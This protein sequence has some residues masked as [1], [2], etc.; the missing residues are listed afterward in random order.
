MVTTK[1]F[2]EL[3][4]NRLKM[5]AG[6]LHHMYKPPISR[7]TYTWISFFYA[8]IFPVKR[9]TNSQAW[10]IWGHIGG[11][12]RRVWQQIRNK[13]VEGRKLPGKKNSIDIPDLLRGRHFEMMVYELSQWALMA[14]LWDWFS[15]YHLCRWGCFF[16]RWHS[17]QRSVLKI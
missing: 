10:F 6:N 1:G 16:P 4:R 11:N 15:F 17:S 12:K 3:F 2:W 9:G 8:N 13:E 14:I 7:R 5:Q